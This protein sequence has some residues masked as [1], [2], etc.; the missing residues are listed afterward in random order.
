VNV[1]SWVAE[2]SNRSVAASPA[3]PSE[4]R[5]KIA[6][7]YAESATAHEGVALLAKELGV[8]E[9]VTV[10]S[11]EYGAGRPVAD[12]AQAT[13]LLA[14]ELAPGDVVLV[15]ASRAAGLD[16]VAAALLEGAA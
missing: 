11:P 15:K 8:D 5:W 1:A 16:R 14:A 3:T 6:R 2:M 7:R 4:E 13:A 10:D 9:L 12:A